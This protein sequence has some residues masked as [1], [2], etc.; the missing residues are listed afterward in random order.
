MQTPKND[1]SS[2]TEVFSDPVRLFGVVSIV[3]LL[4]LAIAPAKHHFNEWR[5]YQNGYLS[6]I[7]GR[8]DAV[9][10]QRHF[11]GGIQQIWH[12]ELAVVDRCTT[13]H[14]GLKEA[15]LTDVTVQPFRK[16][17]VIPHN[18][19]QFGC[20]M[21][22]RGQGVATT[23]EEAHS[24][25]LAW[26]QPLLP[27]RYV[28]SSCGQCHRA[29]LTGTPQLNEG[30]RLL[31]ASG[32][33][34][35]HTVK[36]PEGGTMRATDDPP[37][38][39]HVA[40]KTTREWIYAWLKDPQS[41]AVSARMPNF[42]LS[43]DDARDISAFLIWNS[44]PLS[45]DTLALK[46]KAATDPSAGPSLYGES[47]CATCHAVQNAAG[48]LV[49]GNIGPEL[50]RIGN[51]AKPEWLAA[52]VTN[53]RI[54]D[55]GTAMP[56]YRFTEA[57][58]ATLTAFLQTKTDSDFLANV[59][60]DPATPEQ[61]AHGKLLV[62][63]Y[64]CASCH[65]IA[66]I[67]K[68]ENFAPE[69][70]RIGSKP[71]SQLIFIAGMRHSLPDYIAGKLRQPRAFATG[72]KMPQYTFTPAQIDALTTALLSL[73]ERSQTLPTSLTVA[74][75]SESSYQPAGKAGQLMSDL[76]CF[77]CHRINGRGS[78]LA[79]DLTWEGSSVQRQWLEDFLRSPNTL[80]PAL[81]RR[82]PRFNLKPDEITTLTDYIMTVYQ[83]PA[84]DRDSMPNS[85]Y[86]ASEIERG[87]QLFY[88]KYA[89]QGCHIVDAKTDKGYIGPTLT[90]VGS[91]LNAAWIYYWLKDPQGLRPGSIEPN[92]NLPDEDARAMTAFLVSQKESARQEAKK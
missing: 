81:I 83:T 21:C 74:S 56:H 36:L 65:Q 77:S 20:V 64:G 41:Y 75:K 44:S 8:G 26:E 37:S 53:P 90:Q 59:R 34:H 16:H 71:I 33:V 7:R 9:T 12:P 78:D 1:S 27:A 47:F 22:H 51:K 82:M 14:V 42:K 35:C 46:E 87:K 57:Q 58:A 70:T 45:G 76:A 55:S 30:R 38:L 17:P 80:R 23:V 67:K 68:P 86:A 15:S 52:W 84:F 39:L 66:G 91:R 79:P 19:E 50:T 5:H 62:T 24:S 48:N 3:L 2:I 10:L 85:G 13:C 60:L 63:E 40:D 89:C 28:E 31:A 69:L 88:S 72:L 11:K 54:Y 25:T 61:I 43:D 49:G 29:P 73:N 4:S 18:V 92:R 32:C 6:M